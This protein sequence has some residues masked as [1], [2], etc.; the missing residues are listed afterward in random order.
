[1]ILT[2]GD[3]IWWRSIS[4]SDWLLAVN[5]LCMPRDTDPAESMNAADAR[6]CEYL[7][8]GNR[9]GPTLLFIHGWPDDA[10]LWRKQVEALQDDY[11]CIRITLPN[12]GERTTKPGGFDFPNLVAMLES[13]IETV[14]PDGSPLTL[15]TH[16]WGAYLGYLLEQAR[17]EKIERMVAVDIGGH[18]A[19]ERL[20]ESLFILGYQWTLIVL[21][22]VGGIVPPLGNSLTRRFAAT[23]GVPARQAKTARSCMNYMYFYLWRGLL[24]PW[25][26][27]QLLARYRPQ[28][29]VLFLW[30]CKKP[31]MFHSAHWLDLVDQSGGRSMGIEGAGHWLME[32]HADEVNRAIRDWL[33]ATRKE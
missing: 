24:M 11:R 8:E 33:A 1:M 9:N 13:T 6:T 18:I 15:I 30:G 23:L 22:L 2:A 17:P 29:P 10:S 5:Q 14:Q 19:P 28:R 26:R 7:I 21:W 20:R 25:W 12:F 31:V 16:D 32:S 27:K 3:P 4:G